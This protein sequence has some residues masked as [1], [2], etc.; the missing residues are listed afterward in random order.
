MSEQGRESLTFD[1][2]S[3]L[4][5]FILK[6]YVYH[7]Y[8]SVLISVYLDWY[9]LLF[10]MRATVRGWRLYHLVLRS[11]MLRQELSSVC[12][13]QFWLTCPATCCF[14]SKLQCI[15]RGIKR[16][17]MWGQVKLL[18]EDDCISMLSHGACSMWMWCFPD[19]SWSSLDVLSIHEM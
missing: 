19:S 14:L 1:L 8:L 13:L 15:L 5:N 17:Y 4:K 9:L 3:C 10:S 18:A 2:P 12:N 7:R 6:G 11:W 16:V